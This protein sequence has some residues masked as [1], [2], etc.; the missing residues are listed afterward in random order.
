MQ[1]PCGFIHSL[2]LILIQ[3]GK[4]H[5]IYFT[6]EICP[7]I[8]CWLNKLSSWACKRGLYIYKYIYIYIYIGANLLFVL[9]FVFT[10]VTEPFAPE[11]FR[12]QQAAQHGFRPEPLSRREGRLLFVHPPQR[13]FPKNS[14][15]SGLSLTVSDRFCDFMPKDWKSESHKNIICCTLN[16]T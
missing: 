10:L 16:L 13:S 14:T 2:F 15:A 1:L 3:F 6:P 4:L 12:N 11:D 7:L 5:R 9:G 8:I